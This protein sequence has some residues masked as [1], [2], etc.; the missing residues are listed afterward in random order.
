MAK[1]RAQLRVFKA[2]KK[3]VPQGVFLLD[4]LDLSDEGS[5]VAKYKGKTVF[6][7]GALPGE[8]VKVRFI[9]NRKNFFIAELTAV[10]QA[11]PQRVSPP[12]QYMQQ[13]G[14]CALQH[15]NCDSQIQYKQDRLKRLID[16]IAQAVEWSPVITAS[17]QQY[18]HRIRLAVNANKHGVNIGYK[19]KRSHKIITIDSCWIADTAINKIMPKVKQLISDLKLRSQIE[20]LVVSVDSIQQLGLQLIC[21]T[22]L[23]SE[24]CDRISVF[25]RLHDVAV[26]ATLFADPYGSTVLACNPKTF[27]YQVTNSISLN[28]EQ[29]DFTQVNPVVNQLMI[30]RALSWLQLDNKQVAD[31]FCGIGNLTLPLAKHAKSVFAYEL[32]QSMLTKGKNNADSNHLS[33]IT[34][35]QSDLFE[36]KVKL[37]D[38]VTIA[39]FDPPRAGA[40]NLAKT[41]KLDHIEQLLYISCKPETLVRDAEELIGRGMRIT[42][43]SLVDMFPHTKHME[44]MVLFEKAKN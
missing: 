39:V 3:P 15:L 44:A 35:I 37:G 26:I 42:K 6:I 20:E 8:Q 7:A 4:V 30:E 38:D 32:V 33:N 28:Y 9:D 27:I 10:L 19:Q 34:F 43:A 17:A 2:D 41:L 13:C 16:P 18:R 31:F 11:S 25:S 23:P 24:D 21:K 36:D 5:G 29:R 1:R 14:G 12:C 40:A 22:Q